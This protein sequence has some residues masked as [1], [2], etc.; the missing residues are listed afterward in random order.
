[1]LRKMR[2]GTFANAP[3]KEE[4][5]GGQLVRFIGSPQMI[6]SMMNRVTHR[7]NS[8]RG[9]K[10]T[11]VR[12]FLQQP[13]IFYAAMI[14]LARSP[15]RKRDNEIQAGHTWGTKKKEKKRGNYRSTGRNMEKPRERKRKKETERERERER[16]REWGA[17]K[18]GEWLPLH[19]EYSRATAN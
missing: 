12:L 6:A 7:E 2:H 5:E 4:K 9:L 3:W 1:M 19:L 11:N 14:P 13:I 10:Q 15:C 16:E 18:K 17:E 8:R